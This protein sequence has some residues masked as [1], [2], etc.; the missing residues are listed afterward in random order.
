[1]GDLVMSRIRLAGFFGSLAV[2]TGRA[3]MLA[4]SFTLASS[5]PHKPPLA[6]HSFGLTVL[7]NP[8]KVHTRRVEPITPLTSEGHPL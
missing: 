1:M 5:N 6:S 4:T 3:S 8:C 2:P 7:S